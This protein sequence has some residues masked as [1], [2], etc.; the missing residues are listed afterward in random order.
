MA[1][2]KAKK[3]L[4]Q[5]REKVEVVRRWGQIVEQEVGDFRGPAQQLNAMIDGE[6]PRAMALLARKIQALEEYANL[7]SEGAAAGSIPQSSSAET[8]TSDVA[9]KP[10]EPEPTPDQILGGEAPVVKDSNPSGH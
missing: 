9:R 7:M 3:R 5:A 6:L 1:L 10:A 4:D 2:E 8:T